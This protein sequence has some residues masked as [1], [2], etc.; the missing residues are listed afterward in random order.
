MVQWEVVGG[1][2]K[3]GIIVRRSS[4]LDSAPESQ[5]LATASLVQEIKVFGDRLHYWLVTGS[6]P[7]EGWVSIRIQG[8]TLLRQRQ[9]EK[10]SVHFLKADMKVNNTIVKSRRIGAKPGSTAMLRDGPAATKENKLMRLLEVEEQEEVFR[11]MSSQPCV[12]DMYEP[13]ETITTQATPLESKRTELDMLES[14]AKQL[15]MTISRRTQCKGASPEDHDSLQV[16]GHYQSVLQDLE[17]RIAT[18]ASKI[19][20]SCT[21][22]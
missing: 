20:T 17:S 1:E 7:R 13:T 22:F 3:G 15:R 18:L 21:V 5:R 11:K 2:H 4:A 12:E 19:G 16:V 14:Q 6:G 9:Q 10:K 8:K